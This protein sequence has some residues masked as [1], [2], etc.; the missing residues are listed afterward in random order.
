MAGWKD[1]PMPPRIAALPRDK[2]GFPVPWVSEWSTP[3]DE[4]GERSWHERWVPKYDAALA[5]CTHVDGQGEPD[6]GNL[7]AVR[8][9]IGMDERRCDVCGGR[10]N[11]TAWFMGAKMLT[12]GEGNVLNG[13]RET[14]MHLECVL[15]AGQVCPGMVTK[16]A[17]RIWVVQTEKYALVQQ[18]MFKART[19]ADIPKSATVTEVDKRGIVE[20]LFGP[21]D[22]SWKYLKSVLMGLVAIPVG[23][24]QQWPL[25]EFLFNHGVKHPYLPWPV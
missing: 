18:R 4:T 1:V 13:F 2:R 14:P 9:I 10:V 22:N 15:Y 5:Y 20:A 8:Q 16:E 25:E 17:G 11:R 12:P 23:N 19:A 24:Y 21:T 7:C 6:L 3:E